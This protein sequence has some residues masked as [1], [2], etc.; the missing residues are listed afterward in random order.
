[1]DSV[2]ILTKMC[3]N[4]LFAFIISYKFV[5]ICWTH[6]SF[7]ICIVELMNLEMACFDEKRDQLLLFYDALK[8]I[9]L[10]RRILAKRLRLDMLFL[11][12]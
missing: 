9:H 8:L 7:V 4:G 1:M 10:F 6:T 2:E 5:N 12:M 11:S 3:G